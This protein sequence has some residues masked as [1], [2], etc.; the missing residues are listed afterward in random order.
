[1]KFTIPNLI[2]KVSKKKDLTREEKLNMLGDCIVN[3]LMIS[4]FENKLLSSEDLAYVITRAVTT[5]IDRLEV[6]ANQHF[7]EHSKADKAATSLT[8]IQVIRHEL[9]A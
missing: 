7:A 4:S 2:S 6:R 1:M 5:S 8:Q 3:E 9:N